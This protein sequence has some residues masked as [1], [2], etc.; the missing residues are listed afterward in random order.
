MNHVMG[1]QVS[2]EDMEVVSLL[3]DH[4]YVELRPVF[5]CDLSMVEPVG[6]FRPDGR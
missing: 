1:L 3:L 6:S 2:E 5:D 4:L